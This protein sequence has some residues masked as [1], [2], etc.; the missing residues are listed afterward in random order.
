MHKIC[1][2]NIEYS[3]KEHQ[4]TPELKEIYFMFM[5]KNSSYFNNVKRPCMLLLSLTSLD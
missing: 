5:D 3:I 4:R 2:K 1:K